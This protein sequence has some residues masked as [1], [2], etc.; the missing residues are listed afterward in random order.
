ML[1]KF[2]KLCNP[3]KLYFA[4]VILFIVVSLFSNI[5]ILAIFFKLIFALIWTSILNWL[6]SKGYTTISW[7]IV[8]LPFI[9]MIVAFFGF[10]KMNKSA[11]MANQMMNVAQM[12]SN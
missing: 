8:F 5:N 4:L 2:N 6:C 1:E 3:A 9:L 7:I 10:L 11:Q 12:K